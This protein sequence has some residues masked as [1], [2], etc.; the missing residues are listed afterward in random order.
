MSNSKGIFTMCAVDHRRS[1]RKIINKGNP[2]SVAY[3]TMMDFK[4]DI[5]ETL[6]PHCGSVLLDIYS[7]SRAIASNA[8]SGKTGLLISL[9]VADD[10]P[11]DDDEQFSAFLVDWNVDTIKGMAA[12]GVKIPLFYRPDLPNVASVQLSTV[13]KL[14]YEC[15]QADIAL[16]IGPKSYMVPELEKDYWTYAKKKPD[17][18]IE[19]VRQL[20]TLPIDVLKVEFPADISYE[21][22]KERLLYLCQQMNEACRVPWVLLSGGISFEVFQWQLEIACKAGAS[23]FLAGRVLWQEAAM[24]DSR[25]ERTKFLKTTATD[26][27]NQLISLADSYAKPWHRKLETSNNYIVP[28]LNEVWQ[29]NYQ[30]VRE[31]VK[32]E[33]TVARED[34]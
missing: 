17:L 27:L 21:P 7:A 16:F 14:A 5:C 28:D 18:L 4:M 34:H 20:S 29:E 10:D 31:Q 8:I 19:T 1:L 6:V 12:S 32:P 15:Q 13:T 25:W 33:K 22:N 30:K 2:S 24:I 26:R 3:Q 23:G 9:E 11:Y